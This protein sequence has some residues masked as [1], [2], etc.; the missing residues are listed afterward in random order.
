MYKVIIFDFFDVIAP[1]FYR[2]WL[3]KNGLQRTGK[4]LEL[5]QE[6]DTGK[7]TLDDYYACL[8]KLSG[9]SASSLRHEFEDNIQY[10][11]GVLELIGSLHNNYTTA[12]LTNSPANLVRLILQK[13]NL[14]HY[15][16]EIIIS[17]EVGY[18]KPEPKIFELA[19][20]KL[21]AT[22]ADAIFIDDLLSY[23]QGAESVGIA[24]IQFI[25]VGQ[26]KTD[27]NTYGIII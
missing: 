14:E 3:E 27:L 13:N 19:L 7:I 6:I 23:V 26:L 17:G 1:D 15:F 11:Q 18:A 24:A 4:Y 8:S 22:A 25:N 10:D 20:E 12:L 5:A 16:D 21:Q 2:V 9:Q